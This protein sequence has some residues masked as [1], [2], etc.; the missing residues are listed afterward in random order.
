MADIETALNMCD[1]DA[2]QLDVLSRDLPRERL[3]QQL[4]IVSPQS[5]Y[6]LMVECRKEYELLINLRCEQLAYQHK[7]FEEVSIRNDQLFEQRGI[8]PVV[9][10]WMV[11]NQLTNESLTE[12]CI[13]MQSS[14][15][16]E[17]SQKNVYFDSPTAAY[18]ALSCNP[19][20]R[21]VA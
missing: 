8:Y 6:Q 16:R 20:S 10:T 14:P 4:P 11:E 17:V 1:I 7:L 15:D 18:M 12:F 5:I 13:N 9:Q 2:K 3:L 21:S 19:E